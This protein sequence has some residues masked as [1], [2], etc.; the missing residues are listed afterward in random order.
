MICQRKHSARQTGALHRL[1]QAVH[2]VQDNRTVD[3][4]LMLHIGDCPARGALCAGCV[5]SYRPKQIFFHLPCVATYALPQTYSLFPG[6]CEFLMV[7]QQRVKISHTP[8]LHDY[9]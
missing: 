6:Q 9:Y 7:V 1:G 8:Y 3:S 2:Y 4:K 5:Q